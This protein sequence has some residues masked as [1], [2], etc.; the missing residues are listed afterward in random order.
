[1]SK[2]ELATAIW[3]LYSTAPFAK[4]HYEA[5]ATAL[6]RLSQ[7]DDYKVASYLTSYDLAEWLEYKNQKQLL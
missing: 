5:M 1:M 2:T 7:D 4:P 3:W 6:Y